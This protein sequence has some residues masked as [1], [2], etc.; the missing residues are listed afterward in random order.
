MI[1]LCEWREALWAADKSTN[2]LPDGRA[3]VR[4]KGASE[5]NA[6]L[7]LLEL[8]VHGIGNPANYCQCF[9][10][11]Y[12]PLRALSEF[13]SLLPSATMSF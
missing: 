8:A 11:V 7:L 10:W 3:S 5:F 12:V 1:L 2:E 9:R 4:S 13:T 6:E